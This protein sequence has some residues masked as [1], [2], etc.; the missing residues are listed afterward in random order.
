MGGF[1]DGIGVVGGG[2]ESDV[3]VL[4]G[5]VRLGEVLTLIFVGMINAGRD[6][7]WWASG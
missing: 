6:G 1:V 3:F 7:A 4:L 2:D 5:A